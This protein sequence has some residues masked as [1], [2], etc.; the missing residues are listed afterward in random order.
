MK[1]RLILNDKEYLEAFKDVAL[2]TD[3]NIYIEIGNAND[4]SNDSYVV[5]T[6]YSFEELGMHNSSNVVYLSNNPGDNLQNYK[7]GSPI[8]LFK[9][10]S[11]SSILA[12]IHQ[13]NYLLFS[14]N[15]RTYDVLPDI[16]VIATDSFGLLSSDITKAIA[17][18]IMFHNGKKIL[19]VSL[20][21]INE[22]GKCDEMDRSR[23]TRLKYYQ[24]IGRSYSIEHFIYK[25]NYGVNYLRLPEGLN[26]VANMCT[27]DMCKFI[28]EL[29][30]G[31]FDI[32]LLD[33]GNELNEKNIKIA[34][35]SDKIIFYSENEKI[36]VL[37]DFKYRKN[38]ME[39]VDIL[40]LSRNDDC[41]E[42]KIDNYVEKLVNQK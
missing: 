18:Q 7:T 28:R 12:D 40:N 22:Y 36:A 21:A 3:D 42:L 11:L 39:K 14:A 33:A 16:Y 23:F 29:C 38:S 37:D 26:P 13:I 17:R 9:Y 41:M 24:E 2:R 35:K 32:I 4:C 8:R 27:E 34:E 31:G 1:I 25:D 5:V 30:C 15:S 6:D 10:S 19:I 20:K